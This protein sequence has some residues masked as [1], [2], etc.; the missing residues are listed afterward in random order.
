MLYAS[1]MLP[2]KLSG[3]P[4][5]DLLINLT[6]LDQDVAC[7]QLENVQHPPI[8]LVPIEKNLE[9]ISGQLPM[10]FEY[11]SNPKVQAVTL[12]KMDD[13]YVIEL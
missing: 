10:E 13:E 7:F 8:A 5:A 12:R 1:K 9:W 4:L 11:L 3:K 2:I 6:C